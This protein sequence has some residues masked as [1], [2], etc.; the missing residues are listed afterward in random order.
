[1]HVTRDAR[2]YLRAETALCR[3]LEM[4]VS[5]SLR[6]RRSACEWRYASASLCGGS[7]LPLNTTNTDARQHRDARRNICAEAALCM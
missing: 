5:I 4:L 3:C 7:A 1:M 2:Q 6:R